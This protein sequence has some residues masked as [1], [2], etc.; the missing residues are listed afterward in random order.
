[1][2]LFLVFLL[3]CGVII[4]V[5]L[6]QK[7]NQQEKD[8]RRNKWRQQEEQNQQKSQQD[9]QE[10]H[11]FADRSREQEAEQY[12]QRQ[13][14]IQEEV[15]IS[16]M[17]PVVVEYKRQKALI[18]LRLSENC[19]DLYISVNYLVSYDKKESI[20]IKTFL[21]ID[22]E[23]PYAGQIHIPAKDEHYSLNK[24][25]KIIIKY[26]DIENKIGC[27]NETTRRIDALKEFVSNT[28][29]VQPD[30]L[31]PENSSQIYSL[32]DAHKDLHQKYNSLIFNVMKGDAL[33]SYDSTNFPDISVTVA[34]LDEEYDNLTKQFN[35]LKQQ[36]D[37][38]P[39]L[40]LDFT[41][42]LRI[43]YYIN[44]EP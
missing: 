1:M 41:H 39:K 9:R 20:D 8:R 27:L 40:K 43:G 36:L 22:G 38:F 4:F 28:E 30:G 11:T 2:I 5:L 16:T 19:E 14:G 17:N 10:N 13:K 26:I 23:Y 12:S 29:Y 18:L 21:K 3:V 24:I 32:N 7:N 15:V 37:T 25:A 6:E 42:N 34:T 31:F 44:V 33:I 35:F